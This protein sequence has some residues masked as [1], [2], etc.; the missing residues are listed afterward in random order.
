MTTLS[1][2][3]QAVA[4]KTLSRVEVDPATSNQRE[5][6]GVNSLKRILG[7][8]PEKNSF[9]CTFI[10]QND[11]SEESLVH[12][13]E[14][15]WYD[16]RKNHPKRSEFRLYFKPSPVMNAAREAD[17]FVFAKLADGSLAAI[18]A[19]SGSTSAQKLR[20][21]FGVGTDGTQGAFEFDETL[22][23]T[24][25]DFVKTEILEALGI[26]ILERADDFLDT[27][28]SK[29]GSRF[30]ST[31]DF[32]S[33]ARETCQSVE[34]TE[35]PDFALVEWIDW[36]HK[37]FRTL[38][39]FF[40]QSRL[41]TGFEDVDDFL[42]FSL[43]VQNRRKSRMGHAFEN[44]L[45]MIFESHNLQ[46]ERGCR[47]E[48]HS[49]PD[50]LFP[51]CEAYHTSSFPAKWLT[52]LGAKSTC[53]ERWRQVLAEAERIPNKHLLTLEGGISVN[54]TNEMMSKNLQ[55][56]V[57]NPIHE[58]Y[59]AEQRG[60]LMNVEQFIGMVAAKGSTSTA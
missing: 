54:Q 27:M 13:G 28:L 41:D 19:A 58:S 17:L 26:E 44:H 39:R 45:V 43:S 53:K 34:S 7:D 5:F 16:A 3:F 36:E 37:L 42:S 55:L 25:V 29:F 1:D 47:T 6:N 20:Y 60:W 52:M 22:G 57:P 2:Y 21:I 11:D 35:D 48:N 59:L 30:P 46:F 12:S 18:V 4:T 51:S 50:F 15:T 49:K 8:A 38:E 31:F 23:D 32:S 24:E 33:F 9:P 40:V 14:V 10:Y 56:V